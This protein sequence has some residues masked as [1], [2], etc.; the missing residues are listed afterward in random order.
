MP[1]AWRF[2]PIGEADFEPLLALRIEVMRDHLERVGRFSPERARNVFRAHFDL[3]GLRRIVV[4]D[5]LAGCVALRT[6]NDFLTIDSFYLGSR[7]QRRGLGAAILKE[8]LVEADALGKPV[9]LE[10]LKQSPADR[11]Y[12]RHGFV[13]VGEGDHDILFERASEESFRSIP[14]LLPRGPGHRF[15]VYGDACSG[16]PGGLH[17]RTFAAVNATLRRLAP[18][19]E[20]ILFLGDEI[21]GLTCD[22]EELRAQWRHWRERE[23][24]WL[25]K[26]AIPLWHTTSNHTTYD[27]MSEAVFAEVLDLPRNGPPGQE[28]LSYWVRHGDL[29]L[30]FVH[31]LWTGLGGE[32]HVETEWLRKVLRRH[33]DARHKLVAGHHPIHSV[34]GFSGAYQR[35]VGPEHAATFWDTLVEGGVLAYLCS[36]ILA[37]DVQVHRGV[38]QVCSAGAGTAH[39]MP[40]GVEYLHCVQAALDI[41]GL[42]YQVL[43]TEGRVREQLSWPLVLPPAERWQDLPMGESNAFVEGGPGEDRIVA[44][45]FAGEAAPEGASAA[46]TLLSAFQPGIQAPL[47]IGMRGPEQRLTVIIGP[48]PRRSP[49]YWTGPA[50]RPGAPFD[51]RLLIHTG[52]GPGGIMC[53]LGE[54]E[55]W[56][57]LAAASPWGA[58]RLPWPTRWSIGHGQGGPADRAFLGNDLTASAAVS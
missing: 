2:A 6:G 38:L 25:D 48:E 43:D 32:G 18:H 12:E 47:W 31:T 8:L 53:S 7:F 49:H 45:H 24:G 36:H 27:A 23:M 30:V 26:G 9:R 13:R 1:E 55:S 14:S 29:L 28:G 50:I 16:I 56:S 41:K 35:D 17:E 39:R 22:A 57:S 5:D 19:P 40:E 11:F 44:L 3:P 46:Q 33:A 4:D 37:F 58:E 42:R 34:N 54:D 52:M 51:I 15:V 21:A 10:V 20:F